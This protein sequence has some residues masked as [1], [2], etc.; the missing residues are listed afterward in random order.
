MKKFHVTK[1]TVLTIAGV[2][3]PLT[4]AAILLPRLKRGRRTRSVRA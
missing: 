1:K 4:A 2:T 3:L